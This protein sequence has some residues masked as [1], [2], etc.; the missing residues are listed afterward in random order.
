[1]GQGLELYLP[2]YNFNPCLSDHSRPYPR[3]VI[4]A[5]I[6]LF[7][8]GK[9]ITVAG[10]VGAVFVSSILASRSYDRPEYMNVYSASTTRNF[11]FPVVYGSA[12]GFMRSGGHSANI[13]C[14][15]IAL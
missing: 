1:M 13:S 3:S 14:L 9:I 10:V 11:L 5:M 8:A 2:P 12:P 4:F 7:S 15:S 6:S